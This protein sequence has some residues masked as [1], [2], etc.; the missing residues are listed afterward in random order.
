MRKT[1][2]GESLISNTLTLFKR[3]PEKKKRLHR[4]VCTTRMQVAMKTE[5]VQ[6]IWILVPT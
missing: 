1:V 6:C 4:L 5:A 2:L 3:P